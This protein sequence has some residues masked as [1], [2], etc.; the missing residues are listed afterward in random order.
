MISRFKDFDV[1]HFEDSSTI[2]ISTGQEINFS[3]VQG[4]PQTLKLVNEKYSNFVKER[5][6]EWE[7][8]IFEAV[9]WSSIKT[10]NE[11]KETQKKK[12]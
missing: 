1:G 6:V 3:M 4:L 9:S 5:L 12:N 11:K 7:K 10:S 2:C 8:L